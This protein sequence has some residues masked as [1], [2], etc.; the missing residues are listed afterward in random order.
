[1]GLSP[2]GSYIQ[3]ILQARTLEW[4]AISSSRDLPDPGIKPPSPTLAGGFFRSTTLAT[5]R[6]QLTNWERLW[7][8]ERLRAGGKGDDRG[9]DGWMA[10]LTQWT[11][12][13]GSSRHWW[14]TGKPGKLSPAAT[15]LI[16]SCPTPYDS[17]DGN[18]PGT[19]RPWDSPD[20]NTGVGCHFLLQCMKVKSER[21]VAESCPTLSDPMDRSL[22]GSSVHGVFQ[23]RVLEWGAIAF[24]ELQSMG[25]QRVRDDWGAEHH[26]HHHH[27]L[28]T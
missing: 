5:W 17:V 11:W 6:K 2:P 4:V 18:P 13:W 10:S 21:E 25:W 23:A 16:Q 19:P 20:K 26:H 28:R 12:V 22:L 24:S 3:G 8:W 9:W 15:K 14:W 27:H 7:C 1:M